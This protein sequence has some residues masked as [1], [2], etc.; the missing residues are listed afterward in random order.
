MAQK[1]AKLFFKL[2][3]LLRDLTTG[4]QYEWDVTRKDP[5]AGDRKKK[6]NHLKL[7]QIISEQGTLKTVH[8]VSKAKSHAGQCIYSSESINEKSQKFIVE[9]NITRTL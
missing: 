6:W 3:A 1:E 5:S 9:N 4:I 7:I 2:E 8:H